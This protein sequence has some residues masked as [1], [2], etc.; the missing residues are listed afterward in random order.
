MCVFIYSRIIYV[1]ER[2]GKSLP[3]YSVRFTLEWNNLTTALCGPGV[4]HLQ[5]ECGLCYLV[6]CFG[7]R[8]VR[9]AASK[10]SSRSWAGR[11]FSTRHGLA[12]NRQTVCTMQCVL[13][14]RQAHHVQ[15]KAPCL[16][17]PGQRGNQ[18]QDPSPYKRP[19]QSPQVARCSCDPR[20]NVTWVDCL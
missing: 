6:F 7:D 14:E 18:T 11:F 20:I 2:P 19:S 16:Q 17:P 12:A 3:F 13:G 9:A 1:P 4:R 15:Q 8:V 10:P 5:R